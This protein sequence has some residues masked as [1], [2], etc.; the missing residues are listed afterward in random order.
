[1]C[2]RAQKSRKS[3][4]SRTD[5]ER[6]QGAG[7]K[8]CRWL[9]RR[10]K[11]FAR[12]ALLPRRVGPANARRPVRLC[13][14]GGTGRRAT[15]RSL[16]PKGRGSSSLLDRTKSQNQN[17]ITPRGDMRASGA[18]RGCSCTSMTRPQPAHSVHT[19]NERWLPVVVMPRNPAGRWRPRQRRS[20]RIS[21]AACQPVAMAG[22][23]VLPATS[24]GMIEQ[25][26]TRSPSTPCTFARE[27]TTPSLAD[28]I[29]QVPTP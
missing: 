29:R 3:A 1:M 25:S 18:L 13:G 14:R 10:S 17:G 11:S 22:A 6:Q 5:A 24:P 9:L 16:W 2:P 12:G 20:S 21:C 27:S 7:K 15:L 23:L 8:V 26:T 19:G 28:P 4:G